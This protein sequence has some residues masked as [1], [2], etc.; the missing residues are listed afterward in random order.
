MF[1]DKWIKANFSA[2]NRQV[3]AEAY[4]E[5]INKKFQKEIINLPEN[6]FIEFG[7]VYYLE[8]SN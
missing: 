8:T 6:K 4:A 2:R 3:E 1:K 5:I 7:E